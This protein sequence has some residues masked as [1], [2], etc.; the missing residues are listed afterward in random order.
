MFWLA[1]Y[2]HQL[3]CLLYINIINSSSFLIARSNIISLKK[4]PITFVIISYYVVF[5]YTRTNMNI[6]SEHMKLTKG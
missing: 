3:N 4:Q 6:E 5:F 1:V 2:A